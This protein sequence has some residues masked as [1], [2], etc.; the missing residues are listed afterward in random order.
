MSAR[1][2]RR[3]VPHAS[4]GGEGVMT[5]PPPVDFPQVWRADYSQG[6]RFGLY[7]FDRDA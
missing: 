2:W 1:F 7:S 6:R 3:G 5:R 4:S